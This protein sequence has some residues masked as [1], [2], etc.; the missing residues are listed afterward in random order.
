MDF[1]KGLLVSSTSSSAVQN[2]RKLYVF[3]N[4]VLVDVKDTTL[5]GKMNRAFIFES[6]LLV[7][8]TGGL[9][10]AS[11]VYSIPFI[12]R[13]RNSLNTSS[14]IG[15]GIFTKGN[16]SSSYYS[17]ISPY[18]SSGSFYFGG[19]SDQDIYGLRSTSG[20]Y[21]LTRFGIES[22]TSAS[23][24]VTN[25]ALSFFG[26]Y[27]AYFPVSGSMGYYAYNRYLDS[28]SIVVFGLSVEEINWDLL[29][30]NLICYVEYPDFGTS[31]EDPLQGTIRLI[32]AGKLED[33]SIFAIWDDNVM[34]YYPLPPNPTVRTSTYPMFLSSSASFILIDG[35]Y[36]VSEYYGPG[37]QRYVDHGDGVLGFFQPGMSGG[38]TYFTILD[39]SGCRISVAVPYEN[40][41]FATSRAYHLGTN[42]SGSQIYIQT[43][44]SSGSEV[45]VMEIDCY[46]GSY[47]V[48]DPYASYSGSGFN[49]LGIAYSQTNVYGIIGISGS[50]GS[51]IAVNL[52]T[53]EH[54]FSLTSGCSFP[55]LFANEL[56][57]FDGSFLA[58]MGGLLSGSAA[59]DYGQDYIS[60]IYPN[61][62][63]TNVFD[64]RDIPT[65]AS[66]ISNLRMI[67]DKIRFKDELNDYECVIF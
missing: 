31:P 62:T 16:F 17:V 26:N 49:T 43:K 13:T 32:G 56:D 22:S 61:G 18:V 36:G 66:Y 55:I 53:N 1:E 41:P 67:Q 35:K 42:Y 15:G 48:N 8:T 4:G 20:S 57:D 39:T 65:S 52:K 59:T 28:G 27:S 3:E 54:L 37:D 11:S 45:K 33:D 6:G 2:T 40:N 12:E 47:I 10:S 51:K 38:Q 44:T 60:K 23:V 14:N 9:T 5:T 50:S 24:Q 34:S 58:V 63:I 29:T 46:T 30:A 25:Y 7:D 21:Y 64:L 19:Q